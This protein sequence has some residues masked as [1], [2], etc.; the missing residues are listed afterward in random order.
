MFVKNMYFVVFAFLIALHFTA[1]QEIV[2]QASTQNLVTRQFQ[3]SLFNTVGVPTYGSNYLYRNNNQFFYFQNGQRVNIG[4]NFF[5]SGYTRWN[6]ILQYPT[7]VN[8]NGLSL[9][10][11]RL[12]QARYPLYRYNNAAYFYLQNRQFIGLPNTFVLRRSVD[13]DGAEEESVA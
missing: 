12:Y 11:N 2:E 4:R 7:S 3:S 5:P 6:N 9:V 8:F 1:G 10:P 13:F